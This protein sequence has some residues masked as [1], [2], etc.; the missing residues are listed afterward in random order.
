MTDKELDLSV[1]SHYLKEYIEFYRLSHSEKLV[2][3]DFCDFVYRRHK[4][5]LKLGDEVEI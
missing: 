4:G 3:C 5:M 2:V 1:L